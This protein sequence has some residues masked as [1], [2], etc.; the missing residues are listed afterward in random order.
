[1]PHTGR[2]SDPATEALPAG[3]PLRRTVSARLRARV[4]EGTDVAML[5]AAAEPG[6][7]PE[8][9][10]VLVEGGSHGVEERTDPFGNRVHILRELPAGTVEIVYA[11]REVGPAAVPAVLPTDEVTYLRASRYCEVEE[12]SRIAEE[13]VGERTGSAAA[14]AVADWVSGHVEYVL[15]SSTVQDSAR[16]TFVARRGV[17]RDFAHLTATLLR[18]AGI[19]ARCVSVYAPGLSPMDFHLVVEALVEGRWLVLDATGL[20]PR[21]AMLR[22]A[23]GMDAADTAF[24]TT[25]H[26]DVRLEAMQVIAVVDPHL[27][28][29]VRDEDVALR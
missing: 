8:S 4:A 14:R 7:A 23:T 27:P 29:D 21:A 3:E 20:A 28:R 6:G 16:S 1:M 19:P 17:C 18:A 9:L 10:E 12:F 2:M 5:V 24:M 11:A 22:I 15:G 13:V 25:L 26:G